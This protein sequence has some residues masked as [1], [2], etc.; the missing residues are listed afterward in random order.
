MK[1]IL[2]MVIL[3]NLT[4]AMAKKK[5]NFSLVRKGGGFGK[6]KQ[7]QANNF[8]EKYASQSMKVEKGWL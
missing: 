4:F 6:K 2:M 7:W 8:G 5:P 3:R 1:P